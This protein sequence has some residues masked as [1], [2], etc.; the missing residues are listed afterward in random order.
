MKNYLL[1][2]KIDNNYYWPIAREVNLLDTLW[3][4]LN[5]SSCWGQSMND[6]VLDPFQKVV[7]TNDCRL[8][9]VGDKVIISDLYGGNP[10]D[11]G[12]PYNILI[13]T[14]DLYNLMIKWDRLCEAG[15]Q[16]IILWQDED[17]FYVSEYSDPA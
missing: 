16:K 4:F 7:I 1:L 15:A 10:K 8:D 5:S 12:D 13:T 6:S 11:E 9:K 14:K 3:A 2:K 17:N